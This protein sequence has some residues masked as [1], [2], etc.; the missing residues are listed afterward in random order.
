LSREITRL[1]VLTGT[2]S[3]EVVR[4]RNGTFLLFGLIR[5]TTVCRV[6]SEE[7]GEK[8]LSSRVVASLPDEK[9]MDFTGFVRVLGAMEFKGERNSFFRKF[10]LKFRIF[11]YGESPGKSVLSQIA[12]RER[13]LLT[14]EENLE[15]EV[16][17]FLDLTALGE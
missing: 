8:T 9:V 15:Y 11:L 13:I 12:E 17:I 2:G 6:K 16:R 5:A 3:K 10:L 1:N 4:R 7:L 14:W